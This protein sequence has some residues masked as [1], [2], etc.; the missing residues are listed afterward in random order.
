MRALY[1]ALV[2]L[3]LALTLCG[4]VLIYEGQRREELRRENR[5][6]L[7]RF[8]C[9]TIDHTTN[10]DIAAEFV[11]ILAELGESCR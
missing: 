3:L 2:A 11:I 1:S 7:V 9:V 6:T 5:D 4:G 8:V 10:P